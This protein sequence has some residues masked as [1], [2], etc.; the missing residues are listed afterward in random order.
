MI[1]FYLPDFYYLF[2]TN[3]TLISC[4]N[5]RPE[6]LIRSDITIKAIYGC[7]PNQIWNGGRA[8]TGTP[9]DIDNIINTIKVFNDINIPIR[10]TYTNGLL[11]EKH[12]KD[13]HCNFVTECANNGM[14][15]ILINSPLLE[16][17]LRE[18]Y[19]N[20]KYI[21]SATKCLRDVNKINELIDSDKYYLVLGDYRDN[22]DFEFLR[23]INKKDK[24]EILI[25]PWCSP[26]CAMREQHYKVLNQMQLG[27]SKEEQDEYPNC[28]WETSNWQRIQNT[29]HIIKQEDLQKYIDMG[30]TNFK[31]E[32]RGVH[33]MNVI[34][35]YIYYFIK[36]E[37]KDEIRNLLVRVQFPRL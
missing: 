28:E 22:F 34:D 16:E 12:L 13:V 35:S 1:N 26:N 36:P 23:K 2:P 33:P 25:D 10:F 37:Y 4:F 8:I 11:E 29:N 17:Y 5:D 24:F 9:A 19:P 15:E 32:G 31:L 21:S 14:N 7:F 18:K 3:M 20:F 6:V 27:F 30:F